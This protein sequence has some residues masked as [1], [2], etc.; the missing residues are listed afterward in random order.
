M[1]RWLSRL[2]HWRQGNKVISEGT[3]TQFIPQKGV[4]VVARQYGGKTVM[5]VLNGTSH[6]ATLPVARYA[7]VIGDTRSATNVL[8]GRTIDL[9]H[10]VRLT[11][12]QTLV[13]EF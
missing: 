2:L 5:T 8:T 7:E 6:A 11:P 1:Y 3:Q 4:Y 9:S 12:R 13:L 10:D